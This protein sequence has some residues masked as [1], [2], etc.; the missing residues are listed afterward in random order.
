MNQFQIC[1]RVSVE[2]FVSLSEKCERNYEEWSVGHT[3]FLIHF[4]ELGVGND[5]S[6]PTDSLLTI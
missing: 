4:D 2:L 6:D 3:T 1:I 5:G